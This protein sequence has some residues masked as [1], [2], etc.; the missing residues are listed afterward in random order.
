[1]SLSTFTSYAEVRASLGVSVDEISDE[2]IA[3]PLYE[4]GLLTA[5]DEIDEDIPEDF[6]TVMDIP[7]G[8][9][10]KP[11][12]RFLRA[13][14]LFSTYAVARHLTIALPLFSPKDISDGKATLSRYAASPYQSTIDGVNAAFSDHRNQLVEAIAAL[15]SQP[16]VTVV[17]RSYMVS[18][19]LAEDPVTGE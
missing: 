9:R 4:D 6:A 17:R 1:M 18:V 2:T 8:T 7:E 12:K 14:R 19:G 5:F 16:T 3:L 15:G 11:Q 13:V 10:T